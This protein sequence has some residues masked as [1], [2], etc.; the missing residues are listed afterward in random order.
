MSHVTYRNESRHTCHVRVWV[1]SMRVLPH[2]WVMSHIYESVMPHVWMSYVTRM[3]ESC[4]TY[5]WGMSHVWMSHVTRGNESCHTY[6]WAMRHIWMSHVTHRNKSRH[7]YH[8]HDVHVRGQKILHIVRM[9]CSWHIYMDASFQTYE[10]T[11][12]ENRLSESYHTSECVMS[13]GWM[14]HVTLMNESGRMHKYVTSQIGM[15]HV[16]NM[17]CRH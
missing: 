4:H 10:S 15:R 17:M 3:N 13:H 16:T 7:T 14:R 1:Q 2:G 5:E 9:S 8:T 11:N 6:E 12:A